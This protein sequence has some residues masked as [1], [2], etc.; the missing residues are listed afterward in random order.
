MIAKSTNNVGSKTEAIP[1]KVS[2][3]GRKTNKAEISSNFVGSFQSTRLFRV[4]CEE[5]AMTVDRVA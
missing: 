4:G 3:Q 5:C 2:E 1:N